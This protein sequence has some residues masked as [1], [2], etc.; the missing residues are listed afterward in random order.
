VQLTRSLYKNSVFFFSGFSLLVILGFWNTYYSNPLQLPNALVHLHGLFM[1]IWCGM[2]VG[3]AFLIRTNRTH[4]HRLV[5]RSSYVVAPIVFFL[6]VAVTVAGVP[7]FEI[8]VSSGVITDLGYSTMSLTLVGAVVFAALYGLAI[9]NRR[10]SAVHG[11]LMLCTVFPIA[12]AALDRI[13]VNYF[14]AFVAR[15]PVIAGAPFEPIV[16][17]VFADLILMGLA[18]WDWSSD[19]RT[20][21]FF[22]V[23]VVLAAYQ[24]FTANA[25]H[26]TTWRSFSDWI[27]GV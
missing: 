23:L 6:M 13:L 8:L 26:I 18:I 7:K 11:R 17:W 22:P 3:Q 16:T 1:T 10:N 2:I 24:L 5:G 25:H 15:L 21:V 27:L 20:N 9:L 19:R 14:P 4:L 12:A